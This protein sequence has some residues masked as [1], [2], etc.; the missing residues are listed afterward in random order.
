MRRRDGE[1]NGKEKLPPS[2][3]RIKQL[4]RANG[5]QCWTRN[6]SYFLSLA[7]TSTCFLRCPNH[8]PLWV[9]LSVEC[10][11]LNFD[12]SWFNGSSLGPVWGSLCAFFCFAV[13][14][15]KLVFPCLPSFSLYFVTHLKMF[16]NWKGS[17]AKK[18]VHRVTAIGS[19]TSVWQV[20]EESFLFR[21]RTARPPLSREQYIFF[22]LLLRCGASAASRKGNVWWRNWRTKH[23]FLVVGVCPIFLGRKRT[24]TKKSRGRV[25]SVP[26]GH[27]GTL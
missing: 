11:W 15:F 22:A 4:A 19:Q 1:S 8:Y 14:V 2:L 6:C 10:R 24:K 27:G 3:K 21:P 13:H 20:R 18:S 23:T 12:E 9:W 25:E 7:R 26:P 17:D 16:L 5:Q